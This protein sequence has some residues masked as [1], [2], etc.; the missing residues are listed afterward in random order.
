MLKLEKTKLPAIKSIT[1][2]TIVNA[3]SIL[4]VRYF[5]HFEYN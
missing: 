1:K 5:D 4:G 2:F 3:E